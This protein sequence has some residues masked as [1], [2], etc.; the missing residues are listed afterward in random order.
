M[1]GQGFYK[2]YFANKGTGKNGISA[3]I[4]AGHLLVYYKNVRTYKGIIN[5]TIGI[6]VAQFYFYL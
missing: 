2:K 4:A 6:E 1:S 3:C 5:F